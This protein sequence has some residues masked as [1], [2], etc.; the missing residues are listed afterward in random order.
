MGHLRNQCTRSS[1]VPRLD[2]I[3]LFELFD[4]NERT[5]GQTMANSIVPL[6]HF[7]RRGTKNETVT[8]V[9]VQMECV[10][11]PKLS[12]VSVHWTYTDSVHWVH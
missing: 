5:D 12:V 8:I 3:K 4:A 1:S 7:V 11:R 10:P 6:P 9:I 2:S